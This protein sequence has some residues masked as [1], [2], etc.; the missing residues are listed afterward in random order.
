MYS[1]AKAAITKCRKQGG[2]GNRNVLD[3][4]AGESKSKVL[5]ATMEG[6]AQASPLGM[7]IATFLLPLHTVISLYMDT[8]GFLPL[9]TRT[10]VLMN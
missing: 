2:L 5:R 6:P 4:E 10:Q 7:Q 9:L 3:L 8:P 1:F